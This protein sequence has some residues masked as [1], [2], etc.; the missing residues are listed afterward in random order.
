[1]ILDEA[2]APSDPIA[3]HYPFS[4]ELRERLAKH[5]VT[6]IERGGLA[7]LCYVASRPGDQMNQDP[8]SRKAVEEV[9]AKKS[10]LVKALRALR[11][12]AA[13]ETAKANQVNVANACEAS[14]SGDWEKLI[15]GLDA[16]GKAT[17][18]ALN[19]G[20]PPKR[21]RPP[22]ALF[23]AYIASM[24]DVCKSHRLGVEAFIDALD[25]CQFILPEW[26]RA[27]RSTVYE[28]LKEFRAGRI[29]REQSETFPLQQWLDRIIGETER[30]G[31]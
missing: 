22:L 18:V 17:S 3:E 16:I 20:Q 28:R 24:I 29:L 7:Y 26:A 23:D 11:E 6:D 4:A 5:G 31:E 13:R 14:L 8:K 19:S 12:A 15:D 10:E 1:M 30:P 27:A 21:G 25:D 2:N 9:A